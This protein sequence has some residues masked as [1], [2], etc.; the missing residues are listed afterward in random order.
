MTSLFVLGCVA[1]FVDRA[2]TQQCFVGN[3]GQS[4][5]FLDGDLTKVTADALV[6]TDVVVFVLARATHSLFHDARTI[7]THT[8]T[9][10]IHSR[11]THAGQ[12]SKW[13]FA[14]RRWHCCGAVQ[15]RR[16]DLAAAVKRHRHAQRPSRCLA[17][18]R[19]NGWHVEVS[20]K[21]KRHTRSEQQPDTTK[22]QTRAKT[23]FR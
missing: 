13:F 16:S 17:D 8:H 22:Q 12:R 9:H 6:R 3:L 11:Y 4:V 21:T 15:R 10:T 19:H 1:L 14:T 5:C 18:G 20:H 23:L 2:T 7:H